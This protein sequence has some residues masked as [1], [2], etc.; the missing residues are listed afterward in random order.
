M[1]YYSDLL[2]VI[3][4]IDVLKH[5]M[6]P[7]R[8]VAELR[9]LCGNILA[10]DPDEDLAAQLLAALRDLDDRIEGPSLLILVFEKLR[11]LSRLSKGGQ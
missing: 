11:F 3:D 7:R 5:G 4:E 6:P 8:G 1:T 10:I 2:I 9:R